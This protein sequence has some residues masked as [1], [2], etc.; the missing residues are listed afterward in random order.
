MQ[1]HSSLL[2]SLIRKQNYVEIVEIIRK[3]ISIPIKV[4]DERSLYFFIDKFLNGFDMNFI[5]EIAKIPQIDWKR[6][7]K[8]LIGRRSF[9][10]LNY[11]LEHKIIQLSDEDVEEL[12]KYSS[13]DGPNME[14]LLKYSIT[15]QLIVKLYKESFTVGYVNGLRII[16]RDKPISDEDKIKIINNNIE[17]TQMTQ[18]LM[19][20]LV[21]QNLP[22]ENLRNFIG[23]F[24][25]DADFLLR[26]YNK[27]YPNASKILIENAKETE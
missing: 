15:Y 18:E 22:N 4:Q 7:K 24:F 23:K 20:Y 14:F 19:Y 9:S 3:Y 1:K 26:V 8:K 13:F 17:Y 21:K 27:N 2:T 12:L 5:N 16:D 10:V 11:L 25:E 6:I